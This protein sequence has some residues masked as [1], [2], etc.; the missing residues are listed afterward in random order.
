MLLLLC[1]AAVAMAVTACGGRKRDAAYYEQMVDSIRKAEQLQDMRRK[2]GLE[3]RPHRKEA[4]FDS[5]RLRTLPIRNAGDDLARLGDFA[6]VPSELNGNLGYAPTATLRAVLL[7]Q[8]GRHKVLMVAEERDS[9][10]SAIHLCTMDSR[11]LLTDQ[12]CV[13]EQKVER[14][15][16]DIG[17]TYLEYFVT[18]RYEITLMLYFQSNK[19]EKDAE[20]LNVRRFVIDGDGRFQETVV[21]SE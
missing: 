18:S 2:A 14:R 21:E 15:P 3:A 6:K 5:L 11:Y 16:D 13:Y 17:V 9:V 8:N 1:A 12:L 20:L 7:P 10:T 4:W 19:E